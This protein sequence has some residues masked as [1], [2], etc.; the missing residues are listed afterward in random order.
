MLSKTML[1]IS[2]CLLLL[3]Q[4]LSCEQTYHVGL[5][6][7]SSWEQQSYTLDT[8]MLPCTVARKHPGQSGPMA[9]AEASE[10]PRKLDMAWQRY[11]I[12]FYRF[13]PKTLPLARSANEAETAFC[14][15]PAT[16]S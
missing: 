8:E 16:P 4:S 12:R 15:A 2:S 3:C 14:V 6:W 7:K 5:N 13:N 1:T 10:S 9:S 11:S